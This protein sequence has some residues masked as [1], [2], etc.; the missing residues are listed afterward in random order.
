MRFKWWIMAWAVF[1]VV[2]TICT[3]VHWPTWLTAEESG[4][5]TIRNLGLVIL[6]AVGLPLAIW[7]S[8]IAKRQAHA[9]QRQSEIA[10]QNM[11]ND[12]FQ[13]G[14]EMLAPR[15]GA[16]RT[17][18]GA[19][20]VVER[21]HSV[22]RRICGGEGARCADRQHQ[23]SSGHFG[24]LRK[25]LVLL[26]LLVPSAPLGAQTAISSMCALVAPVDGQ[27]TTLT[28]PLPDGRQASLNLVAQG[29]PAFRVTTTASGESERVRLSPA[30]AAESATCIVEAQGGTTGS[31]GR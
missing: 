3:W 29:V 9:A 8:V 22:A 5:T 4:S 31:H 18:T 12:R 6:A 10:G 24:A 2:A 20:E 17:A 23:P 27:P 21:A 30:E 14:V 16:A 26:A 15:A 28:F 19:R 11:L 13:K 25:L 1:L 7:R